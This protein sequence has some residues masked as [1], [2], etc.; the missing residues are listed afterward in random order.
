MLN[1][2]I[3]EVI[4]CIDRAIQEVHKS[5]TVPRVPTV[6]PL[7]RLGVHI[8]HHGNPRAM[9]LEQGNQQV[10]HLAVAYE[11]YVWIPGLHQVSQEVGEQVALQKVRHQEDVA[12][13]SSELG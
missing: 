1:H 3:A 7:G 11:H 2:V 8:V 5:V 12:G 4:R 6:L 10:P 13:E 9:V